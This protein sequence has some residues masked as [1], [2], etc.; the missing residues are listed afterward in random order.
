M[1][2]LLNH[3]GYYLLPISKKSVCPLLFCTS[4]MRMKYGECICFPVRREDSVC[5]ALTYLYQSHWLFHWNI[6][7]FYGCIRA[8]ECTIFVVKTLIDIPLTVTLHLAL[9]L[10]RTNS[11]QSID[12]FVPACMQLR[13]FA[14]HPCVHF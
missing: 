8:Y 7:R 11:G 6:F 2:M 10:V 13:L 14:L 1:Y 12:F 5:L 4:I 9:G 3:F